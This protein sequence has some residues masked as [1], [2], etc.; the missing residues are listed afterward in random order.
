MSMTAAQRLGSSRAS[1]G[2]LHDVMFWSGTDD[3]VHRT[4][5]FVRGGL[6]AGEPVMVAL[7]AQRVAS[8]RRSLGPEAAAVR[9]AEM[10]SLGAN[11]ACIIN[12]WV[13]FVEETGRRPSRGVGEPLWPGR[14]S[15]EI[16]EC[17]LHEA[18]LNTAIGAHTPLWLRCP[19]DADLLPGDVLDE[20]RRTHPWVAE[21]GG[22]SAASDRYAGDDVGELGFA[23]T[24][25]EP[26]SRPVVRTVDPESLRA[27]RDLVVYAAQVGGA[28]TDRCKDLGLA[29]HEL[30][31]NT[32]LHGGGSGVLRLWREPGD[33][34]CEVRDSGQVTDPLTGRMRPG[35]DEVDGRGL[36]MV[37]QLCDLVQLRSGASGTTVRVHTWL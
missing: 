32:I 26:T 14:R 36:W 15:A 16:S 25:P 35:D 5:A 24:L 8:V 28:S 12:A 2:Y 37:N 18:L 33:L 13:D 34:V 31:V 1:G 4:V 9:F 11:P 30:C 10:E 23:A 21:G 17:Q 3:F 6:E 29:V 27:L 20:A 7:P 22:R 19:Y